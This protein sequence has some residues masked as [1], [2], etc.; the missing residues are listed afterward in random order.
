MEENEKNEFIKIW[1]TI[2]FKEMFDE[3]QFNEFQ[4]MIILHISHI[5]FFHLIFELFGDFNENMN[6]YKNIIL[7]KNKYNS[8]I[9]LVTNEYLNNLNDTFID[10]SANL[11]YILE[12]QKKIGKSFIQ[13]DLINKLPIIIIRKIF[14]RLLS[15]FKELSDEIID[16]IAKF[17]SNGKEN[18]SCK[19]LINNFKELENI[20]CKKQILNKLSNSLMIDKN[21][22]FYEQ[23]KEPILI[24]IQFKELGIFKDKNF[25]HTQYVQ[26]LKSSTKE[27]LDYI[28]DY[29][30]TFNELKKFPDISAT[31]KKSIEILN[32]EET[33]KKSDIEEIVNNI[34]K[35]KDKINNQITL[36][37]RY[38]IINKTFYEVS[39]NSEITDLENLINILKNKDLKQIDNEENIKKFEEYKSKYPDDYINDRLFLTTSEIFKNIYLFLK[40]I[41]QNSEGYQ[42]TF[43]DALTHFESLKY[44][45]EK[46]PNPKVNDDI[47]EVCLETIRNK[48]YEGSAIREMSILH[49]YFK[50]NDDSD[51]ELLGN[52][53]EIC[54]RKN[55]I[56]NI[57]KGIILFIY[58][59][60]IKV[61][62]FLSNLQNIRTQLRSRNFE[63]NKIHEAFDE[64]NI[65]KFNILNDNNEGNNIEFDN[66]I[67]QIFNVVAPSCRSIL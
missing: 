43:E 26:G 50:I 16:E 58:L 15:K 65:I 53:L 48:E 47:F 54:S 36:F 61:T 3:E 11:I 38:L 60:E 21:M 42:N 31:F 12:Q 24:L 7:F 41:N 23:K 6:N 10:D 52:S 37:N 34:L 28:L 1:K 5:S 49:K 46:V 64:L 63:A 4:K 59:K 22:V 19:N 67:S 51:F 30:I 33:L 57:I 17:F 18:L 27:Y 9:Q 2:N 25:E 20:K 29:K 39:K 56:L 14:F 45:F 66:E 32:I 55:E 35:Y 8:L 62:K 40:K 13:D 44:L